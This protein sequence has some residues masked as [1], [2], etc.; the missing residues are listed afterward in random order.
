MNRC[1]KNGGVPRRRFEIARNLSGL[2]KHPPRH[3]AGSAI[4]NMRPYIGRGDSGTTPSVTPLIE[5]ELREVEQHEAQ[6]I[7]PNF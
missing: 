1:T 2:F 4:L 5:L 3:G 7:V 6:Q